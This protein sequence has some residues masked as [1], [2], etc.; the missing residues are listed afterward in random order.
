[1]E[2]RPPIL[3][4]G[5]TTEA[6][7][8]ALRFGLIDCGFEQTINIGQVGNDASDLTRATSWAGSDCGSLTC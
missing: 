3:G 6:A 8:A 5:L 7:R 4:R 2:A 1:M